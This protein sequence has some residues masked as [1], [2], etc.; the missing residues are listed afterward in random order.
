VRA[1]RHIEHEITGAIAASPVTNDTITVSGSAGVVYNN[2]VMVW[3]KTGGVAPSLPQAP[4][5]VNGSS[6]LVQVSTTQPSG[7]L[8]GDYWFTTTANP[9][10]G[11]GFTQITTNTYELA[12]YETFSSAFSNVNVTIGTGAGTTNCGYGE[13]IA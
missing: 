5:V 3:A 4:V 2:T 11:S 12:E 9:T 13:L 8:F 6:T 7:V 10:N 1:R